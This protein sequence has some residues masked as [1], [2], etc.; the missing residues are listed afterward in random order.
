MANLRHQA[1]TAAQAVQVVVERFVT[2]D[3]YLGVVDDSI[4]PAEQV[5]DPVEE[6]ST[7]LGQGEPERQAFEHRPDLEDLH[8]LRR[9]QLGDD[10]PAVG[11]RDEAFGMQ[12]ADGVA[13]GNPA[14][15]QVL[16]DA[17]L[18]EAHAARELAREDCATKVLVRPLL[19][20]TAGR[21]SRQ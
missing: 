19:G 3:P 18:P 2:L 4:H 16:G 8:D 10:H 9:S 14:D 7:Q 5:L 6:L 20:G 11:Q 12:P 15:P 17:V 13:Y 21:L 1:G